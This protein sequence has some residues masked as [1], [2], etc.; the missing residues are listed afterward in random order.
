MRY[1]LFFVLVVLPVLLSAQPRWVSVDVQQLRENIYV[2]YQ[3]EAFHAETQV[4]I[5]TAASQA[6][7]KLQIEYTGFIRRAN[8]GCM[9]LEQQ[10]HGEGIIQ[11]KIDTLNAF[12]DFIVDSLGIM[13]GILEQL[14][15]EE[16]RTEV[17]SFANEENLQAVIDQANCIYTTALADRTTPVAELLQN[18]RSIPSQIQAYKLTYRERLAAEIAKITWKQGFFQ[19]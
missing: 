14:V 6:V 8:G 16:I 7:R 19:R 11:A 4:L 12:E 2:Q 9:T 1:C 18:S 15:H 13:Q 3:I 10:R 5:D 17:Q